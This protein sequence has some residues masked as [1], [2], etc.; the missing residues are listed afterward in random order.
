MVTGHT[1]TDR[2]ETLLLNLVRGAGSDGLQV[3][4]GGICGTWIKAGFW[5]GERVHAYRLPSSVPPRTEWCLSS[6]L[7]PSQALSWSRG[8]CPGV[9]LVRPLLEVGRPRTLAL[10]EQYGLAVWRDSTNSN[11][12]YKRN[13]VRNELMPYLR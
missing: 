9:Q 10:C 12:G 8:L 6:C 7:A 3:N 1:A 4:R 11:N 2:S 13:R 5:P